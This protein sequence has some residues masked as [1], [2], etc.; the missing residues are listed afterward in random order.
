MTLDHL[1]DPQGIKATA[2]AIY[3]GGR[4]HPL[5]DL[6][7]LIDGARRDAEFQGLAE[8]DVA[9]WIAHVITEDQKLRIA[10][11]DLTAPHGQFVPNP[12]K[13]VA[14][15]DLPEGSNLVVNPS[16]GKVNPAVGVVP[17][18]LNPPP[19][20]IELEHL[21]HSMRQALLNPHPGENAR[22]IIDHMAPGAFDQLKEMAVP[23][24]EYPSKTAEDFLQ[25]RKLHITTP[26]EPKPGL[27]DFLKDLPTLPRVDL[28][29][30]PNMFEAFKAGKLTYG[31]MPELPKFELSEEA[32][33]NLN[34]AGKRIGEVLKEAAQEVTRRTRQAREEQLRSYYQNTEHEHVFGRGSNGICQL[35]GAE[36]N[37]RRARAKRRAIHNEQAKAAR[38]YP[39]HQRG[40]TVTATG[41][42]AEGARV[43]KRGTVLN[44]ADHTGCVGVVWEDQ[45]PGT[46]SLVHVHS[47]S[48]PMSNLHEALK[49]KGDGI[50]G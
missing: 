9:R 12:P 16:M 3:E 47:L 44:P 46:H 2:R 23:E 20:V 33:E 41:I 27:F 30:Q 38:Q 4:E 42:D 29:D 45:E 40:E 24:T 14:G 21:S 43:A 36:S 32:R 10:N 18:Y 17:D 26:A 31:E 15:E 35:C 28:G 22:W 37:S 48:A 6:A 1:T 19:P 34:E 13:L 8:Y 11:N 7:R 49:A 25:G 39:Q 50:D 5:A